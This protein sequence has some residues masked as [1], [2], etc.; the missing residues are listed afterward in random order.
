ME[1]NHCSW[2][3]WPG[4]KFQLYH[5]PAGDQKTYMISSAAH[6]PCPNPLVYLE[7]SLITLPWASWMEMAWRF[8]LYA[9]MGIKQV[10]SWWVF[11]HVHGSQYQ[12]PCLLPVYPPASLTIFNSASQ[13]KKRDLWLS[14]HHLPIAEGHH[15]ISSHL[16]NNTTGW[17]LLCPFFWRGNWGSRSRDLPNLTH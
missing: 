5:S 16:S 1:K 12:L 10:V 2:V 3:R 6:S 13:Y 8:N 7:K 15:F 9:S 17:M 4:C 11:L 14:A